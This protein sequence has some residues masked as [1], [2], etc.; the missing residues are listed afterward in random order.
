MNK[1]AKKPRINSSGP[2]RIWLMGGLG[3]VLFQLAYAKYLEHQGHKVI[4]IENLLFESSITKALGW[5]IRPLELP[6]LDE[7]FFTDKAR[8][9]LPILS[10][11]LPIFN[12]YSTFYEN[13]KVSVSKNLFGYFQT[14]EHAHFLK[15]RN[16]LN[17]VQRGIGFHVRLNDSHF[18][19]DVQFYMQKV[20]SYLKPDCEVSVYSDNI[21]A[22][23][24]LDWPVSCDIVYPETQAPL[25][26][27]NNLMGHETLIIS[28]S[29]FSWWAAVLSEV[30]RVVVVPK[31]LSKQIGMPNRYR[32]MEQN[33]TFDIYENK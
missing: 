4:L 31:R 16:S 1:E 13:H 5:T 33:S 25:N 29:T 21:C 30:L 15:L 6:E 14:H 23:K 28:D 20:L 9:C 22:A 8:S 17:E 7:E 11:K 2:I 10:A 27:F 26:D 18:A 3:N 19:K 24:K 32:L 12:K